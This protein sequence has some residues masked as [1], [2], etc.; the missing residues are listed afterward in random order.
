MQG[1]WEAQ[2]LDRVPDLIAGCGTFI[3]MKSQPESKDGLWIRNG[4]WIHATKKRTTEQ[5]VSGSLLGQRNGSNQRLHRPFINY[6]N[7]LWS[8]GGTVY[9]VVAERSL[10]SFWFWAVGKTI[11]KQE[12]HYLPGS[13]GQRTLTP[14][15]KGR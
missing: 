11:E 8:H 14:K 1:E 5:T 12:K 4:L 7:G 10:D 6:T 13:N 3:S 2:T 15:N 9:G